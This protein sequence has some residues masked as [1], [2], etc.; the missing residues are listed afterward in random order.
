MTDSTIEFDDGDEG[1]IDFNKVKFCL[2]TRDI[3][4]LD[5]S[6]EIAEQQDENT[7]H[8]DNK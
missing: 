4:S 5:T 3:G 8:F 6:I 2:L 7:Q 1:W